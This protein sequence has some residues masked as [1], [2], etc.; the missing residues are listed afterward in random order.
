MQFLRLVEV[1]DLAALTGAVFKSMNAGKGQA[2]VAELSSL[3][4]VLTTTWTFSR[5]FFAIHSQ[6]DWFKSMQVVVRKKR[7]SLLPVF[8]ARMTAVCLC[9]CIWPTVATFV[10]FPVAGLVGDM[11]SLCNISFLL[12]SN[13]ICYIFLGMALGQLTTVPQAMIAAT[14]LSQ[15]SIV[16]SGV[17]TVLPP[18]LEWARYFSP[19]YWTVQGLVKSVFRWSDTY[20]CVVGSSSDAGADQCFIEYD[21]LIDLYKRRGLYD[22]SSDDVIAE[23]IT[24]VALSFGLCAVLFCRSFLAYYRVN[25]ELLWD[26]WPETW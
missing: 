6:H 24:L 4:L 15:I 3:V 22:P 2:T 21:G 16:V 26:L 12:S 1:V 19:F 11:R 17:F 13:N 25:W 5:L 20:E 18:S 7:F 10:C 9:E 23:S 8:S 14:I